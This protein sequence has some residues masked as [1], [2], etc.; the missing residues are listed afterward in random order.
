[1]PRGLTTPKSTI[2]AAMRPGWTRC[3]LRVRVVTI[4]RMGR[5]SPI[6]PPSLLDRQPPP[7]LDLVG[8]A[9]PVWKRVATHLHPARG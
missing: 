8:F 9:G 3:A 7:S 4:F 2:D 6:N 5:H 1:M